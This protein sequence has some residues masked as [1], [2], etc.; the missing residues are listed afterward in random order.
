MN[1]LDSVGLLISLL[2][3]R[4]ADFCRRLHGLAG[5]AV[6]V[7]LATGD[8]G[9]GQERASR[10]PPDLVELLLELSKPRSQL[11]PNIIVCLLPLD[12]L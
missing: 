11:W 2:A 1:I 3:G 4:H 8:A 6:R 9:L 12:L 5:V 7:C 10:F